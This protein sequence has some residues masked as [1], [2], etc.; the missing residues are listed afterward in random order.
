MLVLPHHFFPYQLLKF[1]CI[2]S[3]AGKTWFGQEALTE[4]VF[5]CS[6]KTVWNSD[7]FC[8]WLF[9]PVKKDVPPSAVTRPIYGIL[10]TIRL[11]AGKQSRTAL[12]KN[13]WGKYIAKEAL[14]TKIVFVGI[15]YVLFSMVASC[16]CWRMEISKYSWHECSWHS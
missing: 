14:R 8:F 6:H 11:V 13:T 12:I 2:A 4:L 9:F 15:W 7:M 16:G 5:Q 1:W 3:N 10:G